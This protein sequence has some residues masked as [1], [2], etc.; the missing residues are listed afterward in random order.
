MAIPD[1]LSSFIQNWASKEELYLKLGVASEINESD[2]TFKFTPI[3]EKSDV[4]TVR[5]KTIVDGGP[6]S[7]VIV[8]KEGTKVV[9]GFHSNTVAQCIVVQESD[10]VLINSNI[11]QE[12][13]NSKILAIQ[14]DY[15]IFCDD[16][17]VE[18]DSWVFNGG[19]LGGMIIISDLVTKMNGLISELNSMKNSL[20]SHTHGLVKTGTDTSG[21]SSTSVGNFTPFNKVD[22][23]DEKIKH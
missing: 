14:D 6:E 1:I 16:V 2:F 15:N 13:A 18:T 7:F 23:E 3:D 5:M 12:V 21:P 10:K 8:P 11:I 9:V 22:F 20:N 4:E 19:N 17:K